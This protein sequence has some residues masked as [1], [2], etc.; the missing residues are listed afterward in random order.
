MLGTPTENP[1]LI[2][3]RSFRSKALVM[4]INGRALGLARRGRRFLELLPAV[5]RN[6]GSRTTH[7][8]VRNLAAKGSSR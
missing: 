4:M 6:R 2:C 1:L 8:R 5:L 7:E 3:K